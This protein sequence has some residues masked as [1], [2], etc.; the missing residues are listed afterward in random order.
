MP[1][2]EY[3]CAVPKCSFLFEE[4]AR[5]DG[6]NPDCPRC[7]GPTMKLMSSPSLNFGAAD[8]ILPTTPKPGRKPSELEGRI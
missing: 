1:L 4:L 3:R 8:F 6:D 7:N 2:Y 5:M